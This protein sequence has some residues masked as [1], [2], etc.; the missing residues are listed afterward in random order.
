MSQRTG[1]QLK[2]DAAAGDVALAAAISAPTQTTIQAAIAAFTTVR[3]N[4]QDSVANVKTADAAM[5]QVARDIQAHANGVI[6]EL[7]SIL[8]KFSNATAAELR[9]LLT[10]VQR[11][12]A[13]G[14]Y[15]T[16]LSK[17]TTN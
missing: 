3:Q 8:A 13:I 12:L 15:S 17:A 14:S 2:S 4:A 6:R 16:T 11:R 5:Q 1:T 9:L 10:D 7:N